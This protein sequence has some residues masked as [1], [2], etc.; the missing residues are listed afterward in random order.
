MSADYATIPTITTNERI[1][2]MDTFNRIKAEQDA[3][4]ALQ[5]IKDKA[6]VEAMFS[7]N[8]RPLNNSYLLAKEEN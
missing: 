1:N 4:R 8:N 7:T 3:K 5:S 2:N 6:I